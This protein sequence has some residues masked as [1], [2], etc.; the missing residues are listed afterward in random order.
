MEVAFTQVVQLALH[1]TTIRPRR[2]KMVLVSLGRVQDAMTQMRSITIPRAQMT[3]HVSLAVGPDK[4]F[5]FR[6]K[7]VCLEAK[8]LQKASFSAKRHT[9][10]VATSL[11]TGAAQEV[12]TRV[13]L[14]FRS[15]V[16]TGTACSGVDGTWILA[17]TTAPI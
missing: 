5:R 17:T 12:L 2:L 16:T 13:M 8:A 9:S 14:V 7:P 11:S 10:T 3:R 6:F 1:A 4:V 15:L